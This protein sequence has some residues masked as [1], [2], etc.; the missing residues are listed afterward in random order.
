[1]LARAKKGFPTSN[2]PQL[3]S[4]IWKFVDT[5]STRFSFTPARVEPL[6]IELTAEARQLRVRIRNYSC[7]K[8]VFMLSLMKELEG[9]KLE[10]AN[11]SSKWARAP[12]I[13]PKAGL[14][15]RDSTLTHVQSTDLLFRINFRCR[16][17]RLN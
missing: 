13:A 16:V 9:H 3:E 5:L 2:W 10:D 8:R 14:S 17:S 4:I 15:N 6:I 11:A 7:E 1:M 12:L